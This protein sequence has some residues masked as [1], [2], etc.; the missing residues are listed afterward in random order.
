[1]HGVCVSHGHHAGECG[2]VYRPQGNQNE[3]T[4]E[5]IA[6]RNSIASKVMAAAEIPIDG[7]NTPMYGHPEFHSDNVH[8]NDLGIAFQAAQVVSTMDGF[9]SR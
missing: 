4:D 3:A 6:A 8:F 7:L 2:H 9:L 5:R 1:V